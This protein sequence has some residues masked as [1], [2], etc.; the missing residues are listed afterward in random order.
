MAAAINA[1]IP[2][3]RMPIRAP[4]GAVL[5]R[6]VPPK[7][8]NAEVRC[9]VPELSDWNAARSAGGGTRDSSDWCATFRA[10]ITSII[11]GKRR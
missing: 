1:A 5:K 8:A 10:L 9:W 11:A 3:F 4:E 7:A 6:T 2:T